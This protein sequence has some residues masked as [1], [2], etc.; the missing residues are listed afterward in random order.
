MRTAE[1][2]FILRAAGTIVIISSLVIIS[3]MLT[4]GCDGSASS[5]QIPTPTPTWAPSTGFPPECGGTLDISLSCPA[6]DL[7]GSF[8]VA[9]RCYVIDESVEPPA[10][11]ET[12]IIAFDESCTDVD[13]FTLECQGVLIGGVLESPIF[14]I[15]SVND[16]PVAEDSPDTFDLGSPKGT[17]FL[18]SGEFPFYCG[19][20]AIP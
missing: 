18:G 17:I 13:C 7:K 20:N 14:T 12:F 1:D 3:L 15:E 8:C 4:G 9:Y 19:V 11:A 16:I 5:N 6:T 2:S 10:V